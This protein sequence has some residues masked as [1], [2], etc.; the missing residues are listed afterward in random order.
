MFERLTRRCCTAFALALL[1][2]GVSSNANS[3]TPPPQTIDPSAIDVVGV[4]LGM[5]ADEAIAALQ[6]SN[7][8]YTIVKHVWNR[9]AGTALLTGKSLDRLKEL[10]QL[11]GPTFLTEKYAFLTDI[12]AYDPVLRCDSKHHVDG[13]PCKQPPKASQVY[14]PEDVVHI[15]FS[16]DVGREKVILIK[17]H[18]YYGDTNSTVIRENDPFISKLKVTLAEKYKA[19]PTVTAAG[20]T[21]TNIWAFDDK[22][23]ILPP[24]RAH[25]QNIKIGA[26]QVF[27][28]GDG[29]RLTFE[30]NPD[31]SNLY[32]VS[33]N[34]SLYNGDA[35][36]RAIL[37]GNE[38]YKSQKLKQDAE[39]PPSNNVVPK[40]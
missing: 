35:V 24:D 2:G 22:G 34:A 19:P 18:N 9:P 37:Q 14:A 39:A 29:V 32:A 16:P 15:W 38:T 36:Y 28:S 11:A 31:R 17:H 26:P 8:K 7:P 5:T 13:D 6:S 1:V 3:Q 12:I 30:Y 33:T 4:K 20:T 25:Q 21:I 27:Q 23:R 10:N 40:L